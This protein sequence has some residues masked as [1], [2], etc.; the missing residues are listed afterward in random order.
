[1]QKFFES[2]TTTSSDDILKSDIARKVIDRQADKMLNFSKAVKVESTSRLDIKLNIPEQAYIEA[3]EIAEGASGGFEQINWFDVNTSMVK[4]ENGYAIT[5]ETLERELEGMQTRK[6]VNACSKGLALAKDTE[7][8]TVLSAG[9]GASTSAIA[10]WDSASADPATDIATAIGKIM[11][12]T[13]ITDDEMKNICVLYPAIMWS[14]LAK[15]I[16]VNN[17]ILSLRNW[18]EKEYDISFLPTRR[19]STTA[20]VT[21]PSEDAAIHFQYNGTKI[22]RNFV[23]HDEAGSK[24]LFRDYFR[25]IIVPEEEGGTTTNYIQKITGVASA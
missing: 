6:S 8:A 15:P 5:Y 10:T 1:M 16:E 11:D 22:P 13:E 9:A 25:T 23:R 4:Y 17:I 14:Q 12:N 19:L 18:A 20:L 3:V 24:Y 21:V 7:I 2:G